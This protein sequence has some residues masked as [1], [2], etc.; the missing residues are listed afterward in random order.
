MF[1]SPIEFPPCFCQNAL[2][3]ALLFRWDQ[4]REVF[5]LGREGLN[6]TNTRALSHH[7]RWEHGV[8]K[9]RGLRHVISIAYRGEH[10]HPFFTHKRLWTPSV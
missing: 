10:V 7:A 9:E 4:F 1:K 6:Q 3:E 5:E 8:Q 2:L